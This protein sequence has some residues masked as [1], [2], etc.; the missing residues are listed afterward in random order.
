MLDQ[1]IDVR[2]AGS[3]LADDGLDVGDQFLY[4]A[5]KVVHVLVKFGELLLIELTVRQRELA[6]SGQTNHTDHGHELFPMLHSYLVNRAAMACEAGAHRIR[7]AHLNGNYS[8]LQS[9]S[10]KPRRDQVSFDWREAT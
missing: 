3:I 9:C 8:H 7:A 4:L 1:R 6:G 2:L 5:E 10:P